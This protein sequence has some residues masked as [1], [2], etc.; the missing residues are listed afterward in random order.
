VGQ[1][2]ARFFF[3]LVAGIRKTRSL[4]ALRL[5]QFGGRIGAPRRA[6]NR[7]ARDERERRGPLDASGRVFS[8]AGHS[9]DYLDE[10]I[11]TISVEIEARL[12]L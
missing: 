11:T 6:D 3:F 10:A 2:T 9:V 1:P 7:S 5:G 8:G 12:V 4:L